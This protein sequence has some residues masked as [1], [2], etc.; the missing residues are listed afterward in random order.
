MKVEYDWLTAYLEAEKNVPNIE[1][2][3][4][5][6]TPAEH[7][8]IGEIPVV[9]VDPHNEVFSFWAEH[10]K[11]PAVLL[12][13]D[14][15][16][17][18]STGAYTTETVANGSG[19]VGWEEY[20][21]NHLA[22]GNFISAG[23]H[24][25]FISSVLWVDPRAGEVSRYGRVSSES[26]AP[27][28]TREQGGRIRWKTDSG[29]S[30]LFEKTTTSE[31]INELGDAQNPLMLD[32]DLD[33]IECIRDSVPDLSGEISRVRINRLTRLLSSLPRPLGITIARSQTP[34]VYTPPS[35]VDKIQRGVMKSLSQVYG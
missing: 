2:E 21:K 35:R 10:V 3:A 11:E 8:N 14:N 29:L 5:T 34:R 12:H 23:V 16:P 28:L 18:M 1:P 6:Y 33:A 24:Y 4:G 20:A 31:V 15:H 9:V 7:I 22:I 25:G 30:A 19:S 26:Q 32:I 27:L 17:D 13:I